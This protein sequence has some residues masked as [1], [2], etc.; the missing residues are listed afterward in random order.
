MK[1][2]RNI[3][4]KYNLMIIIE[5]LVLVVMLGS[6][7]VMY[8]QTYEL[9]Y[10][11]V[12]KMTAELH[13]VTDFEEGSD[14]QVSNFLARLRRSNIYIA[15]DCDSVNQYNGYGVGWEVYDK[16]MNILAESTDN[17]LMLEWWPNGWGD[18]ISE[19]YEQKA[20]LVE[21]YFTEEEMEGAWEFLSSVNE[22]PFGFF[23]DK[24]VGYYDENNE[25]VPVEIVF[26][27]YQSKEYTL[28]SKENMN[29][30]GVEYITRKGT[31]AGDDIVADEE[32]EFSLIFLKKRKE[33]VNEVVEKGKR[34]DGMIYE[35]GYFYDYLWLP[36]NASADEDMISEEE[37]AADMVKIMVCADLNYMTLHNTMFIIY[38][39][40]EI[41][42]C[43]LIE[44]GII[45]IF[46]KTDKRRK[47]LD[48]MKYTFINAMA[49]EMKTP[50]AV[51]VNSVECIEDGVKPEKQ[52]DYLNKIQK[53]GLHMNRLLLDMLTY[54]KLTDEER[55]INKEELN[56]KELFEE[57]LEHYTDTIE[58]KNIEIQWDIHSDN[59]IMADRNLMEMVADNYMS[60]A[61]KYC[62]QSGLIKITMEEKKVMV[63]NQGESIYP[64]QLDAIWEPLHVV[65]KARKNREGS[66]GMGLAISAKI[67]D[68]HGMKYGARNTVDGVEFYI[69]L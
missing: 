36:W 50:A 40:I 34:N 61:V 2:M 54:T 30:E 65:D 58:K 4:K 15:Y 1:K 56:M 37:N 41:I 39:I 69:K 46:R 13:D 68:L 38:L 5:L 3:W 28:Q 33:S 43:L 48:S 32:G 24:V 25:F 57:V 14:R 16:D 6:A 55:K 17:D 27:E 67:M 20:Y 47:Y 52:R 31:K 21:N 53:E 10:E 63:F 12:A 59:I 9:E 60:N 26:F 19:P 29:K 45:Y 49:H 8:K 64:T 44:I 7:V 18:N 35:K 62:S 51:I 66:S 11:K 42:L 23:I 22:N